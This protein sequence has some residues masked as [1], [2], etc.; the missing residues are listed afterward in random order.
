MRDGRRLAK[1]VAGRGIDNADGFR[2]LPRLETARDQL[3]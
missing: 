2:R 3:F 1:L